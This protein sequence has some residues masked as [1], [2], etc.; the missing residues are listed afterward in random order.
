MRIGIVNDTAMAVEV[1]QRAVARDPK[2]RVI[3]IARDGIEAVECCAR[4]TPD[5]VLM[6]LIMPRMD[7]VEATR[8]IMAATPC[9]IVVVTVNVGANARLVYDAMGNGALDAV[10]TPRFGAESDLD[11]APLLAKIDTIRRLIGDPEQA[12]M[13]AKSATAAFPL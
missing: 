6:D 7:G 2:H 12:P 8:R 3:W 1:L 10:D 5:V 13:Q 4:E 9:A 11:A